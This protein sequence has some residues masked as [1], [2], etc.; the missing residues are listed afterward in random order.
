MISEKGSTSVR[1]IWKFLRLYFLC[2]EDLGGDIDL[3]ISDIQ[4][5]QL[6]FGMSQSSEYKSLRFTQVLL[7]F[8]M[9]Q[10][11]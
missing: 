7:Y 8:V 3:P 11:V 5:L 6:K 2:L 4:R 10:G 9:C 1:L